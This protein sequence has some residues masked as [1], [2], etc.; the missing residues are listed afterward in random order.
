MILVPLWTLA[1]PL[2]VGRMMLWFGVDWRA[3]G[4]GVDL[5]DVD[6]SPWFGWCG[7]LHVSLLPWPNGLV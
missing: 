1:V 2:G 5:D 6:V 7:L 4:E 3:I